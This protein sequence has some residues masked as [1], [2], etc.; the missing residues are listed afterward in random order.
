MTS[1][2]E[3]NSCTDIA[4]QHNTIAPDPQAWDNRSHV[5]R[6]GGA[7]TRSHSCGAC[8]RPTNQ[9]RTKGR[10]MSAS[11]DIG[12]LESDIKT[13]QKTLSAFAHE[14]PY[15]QLLKFIHQPGWTTP[16]E[17]LLVH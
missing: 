2:T 10:T 17:F 14:D 4:M 9:A 13:L 6:Q 1:S 11:H 15:A 5:H 7:R 12:R 8:G 3:R 16:A